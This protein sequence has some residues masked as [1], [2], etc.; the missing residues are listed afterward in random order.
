[1]RISLRLFFKNHPMVNFKVLVTVPFASL[2]EGESERMY[3]FQSRVRYSETDSDGRLRLDALFNYM[4]DCGAF[5]ENSLKNARKILDQGGLAW[6]VNAWQV[7]I[8]TLPRSGEAIIIGTNLY[9]YRAFLGLRNFYI[10]NDQGETLTKANSI[11][12]LFRLK[13]GKLVRVPDALASEYEIGKPMAMEYLPRK[14]LY[15]KSQGKKNPPIRVSPLMI[16]SNGHMNNAQ[17]LRLAELFLPHGPKI[18]RVRVEYK[19]Q[20]FPG[21]ILVPVIRKENPFLMTF[22]DEKQKPY[23]TVELT[24]AA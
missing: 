14:I 24:W 13:E 12:S 2:K 4:Q 8:K 20:A 3:E 22:E 23:C 19:N 10:K 21:E 6:V 11:W 16:D 7:D 9:E 5:E 18:Q 17:Y 1:M 15:D